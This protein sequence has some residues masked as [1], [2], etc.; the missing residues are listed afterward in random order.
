VGVR[1]VVQD[2]PDDRFVL[3]EDFLSGISRLEK[4]N[5][6][7]DILI[8]P[9]QL[10]AA[11]EMVSRFPNQMFVLNHIAKPSMKEGKISPW[12]EDIQRL[13][14]FDTVYCKLSGMVTEAD[15]DHWKPEDFTPY[16]DSV[17]EAFG[18]HRLTIGS[19]WPVCTL[20]GTYERVIS[21]ADHYLSQLS[22]DEQKTVW[23]INPVAL[24]GLK[25]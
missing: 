9:H 20:A 6:V 3:R 22:A 24:Y 15:W 1:H 12:K 19:D 4:Y 14:A 18:P 8:F 13:A 16:M 25:D 7:Y 5:L 21:L 23:E 17:L 11:I 2:E 10:E